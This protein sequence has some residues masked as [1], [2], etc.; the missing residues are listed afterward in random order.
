MVV[1]PA[2]FIKSEDQVKSGD[3]KNVRLQ[4]RGDE[5]VFFRP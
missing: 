4:Q 5:I 3:D 1:A 2:S